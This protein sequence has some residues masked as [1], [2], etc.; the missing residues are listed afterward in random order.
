MDRLGCGWN[1][2]GAAI[3]RS[4]LSEGLAAD[5]L[6]VKMLGRRLIASGDGDGASMA[7]SSSIWSSGMVRII[8]GVLVIAAGVFFLR[9]VEVLVEG[10]GFPARAR[11]KG[12]TRFLEVE[13]GARQWVHGV[14]SSSSRRA[15]SGQGGR[16]MEVGV[17]VGVEVGGGLGFER[18]AVLGVVFGVAFEVAFG[19][20]LNGG[21][22]VDFSVSWDVE[23]GGDEIKGIS[24]AVVVVGQRSGGRGGV[25]FGRDA[26]L[27]FDGIRRSGVAF[28]PLEQFAQGVSSSSSRSS[29]S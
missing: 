22:I 10:L 26:F 12:V 28:F 20:G 6:P 19:V 21:S 17:E 27:R 29:H 11:R 23:T 25:F 13:G 8:F 3:E 5:F 7:E 9:G 24:I 1:N 4:L 18:G 14:G 2:G 16:G 15:H